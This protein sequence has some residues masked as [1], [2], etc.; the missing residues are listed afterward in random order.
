VGGRGVPVDPTRAEWQTADYKAGDVLFFTT[1]TIYKAL[2]N[3]TPDGMRF[4]TD[5]RYQRPEED[6]DPSA[7][8][9]H[10]NLS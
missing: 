7:L 3:L 9:P 1:L 5:N 6:I 10:F 2:P 8:M 4:S